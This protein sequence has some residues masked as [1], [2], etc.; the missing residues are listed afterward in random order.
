MVCSI[1]VFFILT[2]MTNDANIPIQKSV[3]VGT[4]AVDVMDD[5]RPNGVRRQYV[6]QNT[7]VGGQTIAIGLGIDAVIGIGNLTPGQIAQDSTDA[8]QVC[9][10]GRISIVS[11]A[12]GATVSVQEWVL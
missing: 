9:W 10:E 11:S 4:T 7:S 2:T 8:I 6:I 12:A 1:G 3:T 5:R